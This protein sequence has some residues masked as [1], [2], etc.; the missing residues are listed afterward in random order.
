[1]VTFKGANH[2]YF[3][4]IKNKFMATAILTLLIPTVIAVIFAS[5]AFQPLLPVYA[6]EEIVVFNISPINV[7]YEVL[8]GLQ[9]RF[10]KR[11]VSK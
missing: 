11:H 7:A 5:F 9:L 10:W 1:M 6:V 4:R 8:P 3:I 2:L